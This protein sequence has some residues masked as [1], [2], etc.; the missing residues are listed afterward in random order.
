MGPGK[1]LV[2]DAIK[3]HGSISAAGR[4][5]GM[6]YRRIWL[7]VD[8]LNSDWQDRVVETKVGGSATGGAQLTPFGQELLDR[9]RALESAMMAASEGSNLD[10]LISK[11]L[12]T[13]P[14]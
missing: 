1:A 9:Y 2:L 7:L 5:L 13:D 3:E 6:S 10:W 4:A 12:A 8:A 14:D 11:L